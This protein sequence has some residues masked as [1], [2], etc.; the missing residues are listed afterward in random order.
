MFALALSRTTTPEVGSS[1]LAV[2]RRNCRL[3]C[4]TRPETSLVWSGSYCPGAPI[5]AAS[6]QLSTVPLNVDM[7]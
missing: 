6:S 4:P 3:H 1:Q 5:T 2:T 7:T